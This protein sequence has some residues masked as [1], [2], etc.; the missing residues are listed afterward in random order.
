MYPARS[1][2]PEDYVCWGE[3]VDDQVDRNE[4]VEESSLVGSAR[5]AI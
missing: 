4:A 1:D 2:T 5:E 3:E